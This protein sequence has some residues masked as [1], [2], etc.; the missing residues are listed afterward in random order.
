MPVCLGYFGEL[1]HVLAEMVEGAPRARA[2]V[3]DEPD[4]GSSLGTKSKMSRCVWHAM[5]NRIWNGKVEQVPK[6]V[7]RRGSRSAG[8]VFVP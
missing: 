2:R 5:P 8:E 3:V 6:Q 1:G 7:A 4:L